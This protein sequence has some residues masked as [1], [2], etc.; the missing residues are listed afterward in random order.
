V[1]A[2]GAALRVTVCGTERCSPGHQFGPAVRDYHLI[3]CVFSGKG[4]YFPRQRQ[5]AVEAGQGFV[6]FPGDVTTY[7]ADEAEPWHYGWIG[8]A[9]EAAAAVTRQADLCRER[10]VFPLPEPERARLLLAHAERDAFALRLGEMSALGALLQ[11]LAQIGQ[12]STAN[13]KP[14]TTQQARY[15]QKAAGYIERNLNH[16]LRVTDVA[17]FLG[18]CRSQVF[19]IF[20][21]AAGCSPKA[22]IQAARIRQAKE[23]LKGSALSIKEI[24]FSTGFSA[25]EKMARAF[26]REVGTTPTLY[27]KGS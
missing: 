18:L 10:P 8:Y 6:I 9:G 25:P 13:S 2:Y 23:L 21:D 14:A 26:Q 7:R 20:Q 19:R 5:H 17:G 27:R 22:Y 1:E 4:A 11:L 3:H 15:F 12:Q 24:A 16:P